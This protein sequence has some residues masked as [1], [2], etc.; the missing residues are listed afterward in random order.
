MCVKIKS[1][2]IERKNTFAKREIM[3]PSQRLAHYLLEIE[4]VKINV[5]NPYTWASGWK[6]PIY[7]DNRKSLSFPAIRD[8]IKT[9]LVEMVAHHYPNTNAISGVAT[10]GIPHGAILADALGV[11]FSYVRSAP[12]SHGMSNQIEGLIH[13]NAQILVIEDLISTGKSSL[14]AIDALRQAGHHVIGMLGL[15]TYGF[16]AAREAFSQADCT[17]HTI[18]SYPVL[19]EVALQQGYITST[20]METLDRW[21]QNPSDWA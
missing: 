6:S 2:Y 8:F 20:Q 18:S 19:L 1:I 3:D 11:P 9:T 21:R 10:A 16:P 14:Q 7:C 4:A 12:K 5:D 17:L 13:D 15:F